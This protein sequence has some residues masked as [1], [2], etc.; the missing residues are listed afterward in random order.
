VMEA[1]AENNIELLILDRPNPNGFFI[2][3]P[4]LEKKFESFVGMQAIPV[5]HGLTIGEYAQMLNGEKLLNGGVQCKLKIVS[6]ANYNHKM[7]YELPVNPSPNLP[8]MAS[9]Y[10]YPTLCFF[11]GTPVSVGRGT[12]F[13]FQVI[14]YPKFSEGNFAFMPKAIKGK[15]AKPMYENEWCNGIDLREFGTVYM[16]NAK[17]LYLFWIKSM[18][19]SYTEKEKFFTPF[20]DTLAGTDALRLQ[21]IAGKSEE[22]IK[23]S[24]ADGIKKYKGVRKKYLLYEDF[25]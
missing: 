16:K 18:Y 6:C 13:P 9:I 12:A 5:V 20:F 22:E 19:D 3:G 1:C 10:L 15:A 11:E 8:D 14:G 24:W 23:A 4:V 7:H 17:S 2:D 21:L 25:E